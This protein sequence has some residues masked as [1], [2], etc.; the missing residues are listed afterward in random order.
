MKNFVFITLIVIIVI[1]GCCNQSNKKSDK[2]LMTSEFLIADTITYP[3]RI[4]N[5]NPEDSWATERLK[6]LNCTKMVDDIFNSVLS[7]KTIA[8]HYLTHKPFTVSDIQELESN[9]KFSRDKVVE[10]EF[11]EQWWMDANRSLFKKE[12]ISILVAYELTD[13]ENQ[14]MGLKAA[15]YIKTKPIK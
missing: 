7:G 3:I 10:L 14:F 6:D 4:K 5:L 13:E 2:D 12:I 11:K 9:D 15:F 8:Y 1:G